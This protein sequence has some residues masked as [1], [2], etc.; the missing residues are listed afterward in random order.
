MNPAA[1]RGGIRANLPSLLEVFRGHGLV[2]VAYTSAPGEEEDLARRAIGDGIRTI[3]A[4]GGLAGGI[5]TGRTWT[6]RLSALQWKLV[7]VGAVSALLM[8]WALK[9]FVLGN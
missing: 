5:V 3:V 2:N 8:S 1:G 7:G 9:V 6:P 4:V